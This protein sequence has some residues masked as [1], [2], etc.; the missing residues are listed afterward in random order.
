MSAL[1]HAAT[2]VTAGVYLIA[3]THVLFALAPAVML[4]VA[5]V[6]ARDTAAGGLQRP[7]PARHQAGAGLLDHQPDRLHVPG[8]GRGRLVGGD[9]PPHDPRL[10]QGAACSSAPAWSSWPCTDEH[11]IFRMGG[12]RKWTA[13]SPSGP[14]CRRRGA[15]RRSPLVTAGFYSKD[16]ILFEVFLGQRGLLAVGEPVGSGPC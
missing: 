13:A 14:S 4:A 2:M 16:L 1:I 12:L 7:R 9:L 15:R 3:R 5:V 11:D 8:P 6:G 10:L